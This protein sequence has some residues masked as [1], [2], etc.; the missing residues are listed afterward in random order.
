MEALDP[1]Q[2]VVISESQCMSEMGESDWP[3]HAGIVAWLS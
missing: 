1:A 2:A 3:P